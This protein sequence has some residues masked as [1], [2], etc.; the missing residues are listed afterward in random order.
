MAGA[1]PASPTNNEAV[2]MKIVDYVVQDLDPQEFT[3]ETLHRRTF[4][5][6]MRLFKSSAAY[7]QIIIDITNYMDNHLK[8]NFED[9]QERGIS[10]A[11]LGLPFNIIAYKLKGNHRFMINPKIVRRSKDM[12]ETKSNCGSLKLAETI[13]VM[14]HRL[15]DVE[16]YDRRGH[17]SQESNI[18]RDQG[19]FTIQHEVDHNLGVMITDRHKE[20]K[21]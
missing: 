20:I 15:I 6:N 19:G 9:Y 3:R 7:R 21:K 13:S 2:V 10:G 16:F 11:S 5:V 8:M 14:R 17:K 4:D 18:G 1:L 12:V